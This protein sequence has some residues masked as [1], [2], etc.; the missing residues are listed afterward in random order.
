[1][2]RTAARLATL[3]APVLLAVTVL[4]LLPS[5]TASAQLECEF[6]NLTPAPGS[7]V[8]QAQPQIAVIIECTEAVGPV[9]VL[10]DGQEV[11]FQ[12]AGPSPEQQTVFFRPEQPLSAGEHTVRVEVTGDGDTTW[13]FTV[14]PAAAPI[15][16]GGFG[17]LQD[18]EP[19][20]VVKGALFTTV[21]GLLTA[22]TYAVRRSARR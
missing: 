6:R 18:R 19:P 10:L 11:A 22:G 9:R 15:T 17:S 16:G 5:G 1:M 4:A 13:T 8:N 7:T 2:F 3:S 14:A 20:A 21:F 12:I